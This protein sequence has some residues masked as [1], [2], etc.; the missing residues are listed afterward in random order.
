MKYIRTIAEIHNWT[1]RRAEETIEYL[2][3]NMISKS[4]PSTQGL[5][6]SVEEKLE[7]PNETPRDLPFRHNKTDTHT[8]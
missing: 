8:N 1:K 4:Y 5:G 7:R 2:V 6:N 3:L